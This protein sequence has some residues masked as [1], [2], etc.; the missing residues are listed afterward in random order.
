MPVSLTVLIAISNY[1]SVLFFFFSYPIY[2]LRGITDALS[3]KPFPLTVIRGRTS[4]PNQGLAL[5]VL[6]PQ[7]TKDNEEGDLTPE[8]V[9]ILTLS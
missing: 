5:H 2:P 4:Q 7:G 3:L 1:P 9:P 6:L 8:G